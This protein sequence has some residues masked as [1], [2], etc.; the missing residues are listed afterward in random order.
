MDFKADRFIHPVI[1]VFLYVLFISVGIA[2]NQ[3]MDDLGNDFSPVFYLYVAGGMFAYLVG[4]RFVLNISKH[5]LLIVF[6][7]LIIIV[8]YREIGVLSF[9]C[10][11]LLYFI[12]RYWHILMRYPLHLSVLGIFLLLINLF[13]IGFIPSLSPDLRFESQTAIFVF[14]YSLLFIGIIVLFLQDIKK[15]FIIALFGVVVLGLYGFRS[16]ILILLLSLGIQILF[17]RRIKV[18]SFIIYAGALILL[19]AIM[20]YVTVSHLSQDWHLS[21]ISLLFYRIGFTTHMLDKACAV[22]GVFGVFHGRLWT[23]AASSPIV[24]ELLAG[25]G[26]ITTT[27]LGPLILDGGILELP[28]MAFVGATM[29]TLYQRAKISNN[30]VPFYSLALS[31]LIVSIDISPVPLIFIMFFMAL[32]VTDRKNNKYVL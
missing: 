4:C 19:G 22:A 23:Y 26:N 7:P 5:V 24:G 28:I 30:I 15:T 6:I 12:Y 18:R 31:I 20:G 27:I 21:P 16:Y 32:L 2:A 1:F 10:A 13:F 9:L 3:V 17:I 8:T 14:G 11:L 25:S 29:N